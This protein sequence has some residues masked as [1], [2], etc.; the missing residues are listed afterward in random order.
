MIEP[1]LVH[2]ETYIRE[3]DRHLVCLCDFKVSSGSG[4][5]EIYY[6]NMDVDSESELFDFKTKALGRSLEDSEK[7]NFLQA[8]CQSALKYHLEA[9]RPGKQVHIGPYRSKILEEIKAGNI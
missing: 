4:T 9:A 6:V 5:S 8:V 2:Y 7:K 1:P 3:K